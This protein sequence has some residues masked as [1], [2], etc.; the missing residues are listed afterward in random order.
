MNHYFKPAFSLLLL[1]F[2][3]CDIDNEI[4]ISGI[5]YTSDIGLI[6][7]DKN[8]NDGND[9]NLNYKFKTFEKQLFDTLNFSKTAFAEPEFLNNSIIVPQII[10]YPNPVVNYG[11]IYYYSNN[12]IINI[13]I[14]D[15]KLN[16]I[17]NYRIQNSQNF[18]FDFSEINKGIYR[19]Y[20]VI[21]NAEFEIIH[22][23]Y[24]DIL[25]E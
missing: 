3:S 8:K 5:T 14:I 15:K 22:M 21:Q 9:W 19:M 18:K 1:L 4:N 12:H 13:V 11:N 16:I 20:Y 25:R 24:G 23:G 7:S 17:R 2:I 10:F 6:S